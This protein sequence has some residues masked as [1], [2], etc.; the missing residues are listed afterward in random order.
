MQQDATPQHRDLYSISYNKQ[1]GKEYEKECIHES[2]N[3]RAAEEKLTHHCKSTM[4]QK[5]KFLKAHNI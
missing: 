3:H 4:L 1:Y 2:L 5:Q